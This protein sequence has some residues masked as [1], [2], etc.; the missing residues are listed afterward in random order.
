MILLMHNGIRLLL[1]YDPKTQ[2]Q[3]TTQESTQSLTF[4]ICEL[5]TPSSRNNNKL[6]VP[7]YRLAKYFPPLLHEPKILT[8]VS[9]LIVEGYLESFKNYPSSF[10]NNQFFN[11]IT[12]A[13]KIEMVAS[14]KYKVPLS[15][16]L[17]GSPSRIWGIVVKLF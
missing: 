14:G 9:Y 16:E 7:G 8:R 1:Y 6:V 5:A 10:A 13:K 4:N 11:V 17:I 2:T 3:S 15:A 12:Y